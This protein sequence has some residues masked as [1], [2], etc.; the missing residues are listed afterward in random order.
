MHKSQV[1]M[2]L[3]V[4]RGEGPVGELIV[5]Y[6]VCINLKVYFT[7]GFFQFIW[8][9]EI[10]N[11]CFVTSNDVCKLSLFEFGIQHSCHKNPKHEE[12]SL[13]HNILMWWYSR[14][15]SSAEWQG[16]TSRFTKMQYQKIPENKRS[17][18]SRFRHV[19]LLVLHKK[20]SF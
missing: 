19:R 15:N 5:L 9:L 6:Y 7:G 8:W 20:C 1:L 18:V 4:E 12:D 17:S 16:V 3:F 14:T 11:P 2:V 13:L 10:A